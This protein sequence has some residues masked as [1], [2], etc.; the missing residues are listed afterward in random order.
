MTSLRYVQM[1]PSPRVGSGVD[2][3][4]T[5]AGAG[6]TGALGTCEEA[7]GLTFDVVEGEDAQAVE[8]RAV[9]GDGQVQADAAPRA[10]LAAFTWRPIYVDGLVI[11]SENKSTQHT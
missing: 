6:W 9:R 5:A 2:V 3:R 4:Q 7:E 11:A 1:M 8:L 10:W